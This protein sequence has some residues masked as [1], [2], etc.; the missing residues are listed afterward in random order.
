VYLAG[1]R[2]CTPMAKKAHDCI[3]FKQPGPL[4]LAAELLIDPGLRP[5][6]GRHLLTGRLLE[7]HNSCSTSDRK[8]E[9]PLPR[10]VKARGTSHRAGPHELPVFPSPRPH[11]SRSD[12]IW[13]W[14]PAALNA[15]AVTFADRMPTKVT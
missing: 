11:R 2:V 9:R 12:T 15:F 1:L 14:K 5:I 3:Q 10:A 13:A 6:G 7:E 4:L 8:L